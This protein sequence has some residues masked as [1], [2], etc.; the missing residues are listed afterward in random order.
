MA[1]RDEGDVRATKY[2]RAELARRGIDTSQ[3]DVR[4]LHG[5]VYLRGTVKA[6]RGGQAEGDLR[7]QMELIARVLRQK[8]EIKDVVLELTYRS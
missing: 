3:C 5:T 6:M 4:V 7:G 1:G 8:G 2:A